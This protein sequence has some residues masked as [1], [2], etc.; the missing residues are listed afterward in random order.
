MVK[1]LFL[2]RKFYPSI[3]GV[4]KHCLEISKILL[5]RGFRVT[6]VTEKMEDRSLITGELEN[7]RL[8]EIPVSKNERV[9]KFQIWFWLLKHNWLLRDNDIIHCHDVFFW[10]IPF[11]L[12][13][14]SKKM[15]IT[16]H[17]WE[18]R[19]PPKLSAKLVRKL[20]EKMV[21][22]NICIGDFI[23]KWYKTSPNIVCY[24]GVRKYEENKTGKYDLIYIGRLDKDTGLETYLKALDE[25]SHLKLKVA[26]IGDGILRKK[27]E[28][29][30]EVLGFIE[31]P[32]KFLTEKT[33]VLTSGYLSIL[34]AFINKCLVFSVYE[35]P[36]KRDYLKMSP[37]ASYLVM[38]DNGRDLANRISY[39][40][41]NRMEAVKIAE[42]A[43]RWA[44]SQ[45]WE[46]LADNY[47]KLWK[48]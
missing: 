31:N 9:K 19:Y 34:D 47:I 28:K 33:F 3:G 23:S 12:L 25:L 8:F 29:Y 26:F 15:F 21:N 14:W 30:G 43:Y 36:L 20:S 24:G 17:G 32:Q 42:K 35:N 6:V 39:Y 1:I 38:T 44:S 5:K 16:F 7:I 11:R 48:K 46:K 18:G 45:T 37:F 4:E 40:F 2:T 22:G 27:V 41:G 13:M 10:V